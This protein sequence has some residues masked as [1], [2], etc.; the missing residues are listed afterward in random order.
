MVYPIYNQTQYIFPLARNSFYL[1]AGFQDIL[2]RNLAFQTQ[3][4]NISIINRLTD[5]FVTNIE[6]I[7]C[8]IQCPPEINCLDF[9]GNSEFNFI[10]K[11][12]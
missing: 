11:G 6:L 8:T 3:S 9:T 10:I 2:L 5:N 7:K 12:N 4:S 1:S